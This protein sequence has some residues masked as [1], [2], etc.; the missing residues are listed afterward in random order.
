MTRH[1]DD[2]P[3]TRSRGRDPAGSSLLGDWLCL[4]FANSVD[5]RTGDHTWDTLAGYADLV[6]WGWHAWVLTDAERDHLLAAGEAQPADAS[7]VFAQA[8]DLREAIYRVFL[9]IANG[10][11]PAP[12]DL[13]TIKHA[14]LTALGHARL[15]PRDDCYDWVWDQEATL[16]RMLWPIAT[17]AVELLTSDRLD[18]VKQCPG[19]DDCGWLFLD[20][21]KNATRRW[22]SMEGCGS[23][24]KMRRQYARRKGASPR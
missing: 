16:D 5:D 2:Q 10:A 19:C 12:T 11:A 13:A 3:T 7:S 9:A 22:C 14:H 20:V 17:S 1:D 8:I 15:A 23:R 21:S 18:R 6:N 24:A 4:D